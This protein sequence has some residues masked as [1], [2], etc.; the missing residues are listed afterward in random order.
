MMDIK[1]YMNDLGA[2]ARAASRAM[3]KADTAAK[4]WR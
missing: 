3:A 4:I 2:R 1:H